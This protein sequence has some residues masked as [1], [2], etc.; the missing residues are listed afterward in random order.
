MFGQGFRA[1]AALAAISIALLLSACGGSS[2]TTEPATVDANDAP[3]ASGARPNAWNNV[4]EQLRGD[5]LSFGE[6][7]SEA[8]LEAAADVVQRYL[9]ARANDDSPKACSYLSKYVLDIAEGMAKR[10]DKRGCAAG[11]DS[12]AQ[13]S[14]AD[15]TEG[16]VR[17]EPERIRRRGKRAFVIYT[18]R[19]GDTYAQ[20]MRPE[21]GTWK[22]QG[23]E[24]TRL[25]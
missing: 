1:V 9:V 22:I 25:F 13:L 18:D 20:L 4:N 3:P 17:I 16:P 6:V 12:L 23:F 15:E 24:P 7:G 21:E 11:V 10:Q 2:D 8:E 5:I 14:T 19:Y